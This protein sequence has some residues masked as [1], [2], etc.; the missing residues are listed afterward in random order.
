MI[1]SHSRRCLQA[2]AR[3]EKHKKASQMSLSC[4]TEED[5]GVF[6]GPARVYVLVDGVFHGPIIKTTLLP[7]SSSSVKFYSVSLS[8]LAEGKLKQPWRTRRGP[9]GVLEVLFHLKVSRA[10]DTARWRIGT[11]HAYLNANPAL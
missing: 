7:G 10:E 4:I 3:P 11:A 5:V 2:K 9:D 8:Q 1:A 6:T